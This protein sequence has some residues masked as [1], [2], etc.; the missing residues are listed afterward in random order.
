MDQPWESR[1]SVGKGF[2]G[3]LRNLMSTRRVFIVD[4]L[5]LLTFMITPRTQP[6]QL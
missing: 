2:G 3:R 6:L 4:I 1:G 5:Y